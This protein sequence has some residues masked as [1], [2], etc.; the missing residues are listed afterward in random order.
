MHSNETKPAGV[1]LSINSSNSNSS[2]RKSKC[3]LYFFSILYFRLR[4]FDFN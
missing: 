3:R 2:I 4:N 1:F